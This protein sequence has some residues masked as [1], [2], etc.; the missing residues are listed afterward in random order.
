MQEEKDQDRIR[1]RA[2]ALWEQQGRPEGRHEEHWLQAEQEL[3]SAG[4]PGATGPATATGQANLN[5]GDDAPPGTP[6]TGEDVCPVC[7]GSGRVE[8]RACDACGGTGIVT[9]GVAGG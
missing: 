7:Q 9:K 5:P 2:H 3:S 1:E 8:N 4:A 6:G